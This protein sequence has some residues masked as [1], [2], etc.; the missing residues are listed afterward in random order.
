MKP[1]SNL[2]RLV[3][4]AVL[5]LLIAHPSALRASD[6]GD[7]PTPANNQGV[8]VADVFAFL[9]PND[10]TQTVLI[11]TIHGFIP[12][13]EN[14]DLGIF[15]A[16]TRYHFDIE[17][18]GDTVP[19][20]SIDVTFSLRGGVDGPPGREILQ[21]PVAQTATVRM[22]RFEDLN[23]TRV[24][25]VHEAPTT[26]SSTLIAA[27][28]FVVTS[29]VP[30]AGVQFFAGMTDDPFFFDIPAFQSYIGSVRNGAPNPSVFSR[31]RDSFAGYNVMAIA[32]RIPSQILQ[33]SNT[34]EIGVSFSAQRQRVQ[35]IAK[36]G[37]I[38][39]SGPFV[40]YDRLANPLV[41]LVLVPIDR[42]N[43][44]NRGTPKDDAK[45]KFADDIVATLVALGTNTTNIDALQELIITHGD[46]LRLELDP[47]V[48]AN[49]GT[50]GGNSAG[51][52]FPNGRRLRDDVLDILTNVITN[53]AITTGDN[54]NANDVTLQNS[55]PFL[56]LPQQPRTSG[57]VDDNTRN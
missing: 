11:A 18:T 41:N 10:N 31:A 33:G 3:S 46:Y 34:S 15:D 23:G 4:F 7:S 55:F 9:D 44:Y 56:A 14:V 43:E 29:L 1:R 40:T 16:A 13:G 8:D 57:V 12:S 35:T 27:N 39:G 50:G 22:N 24:T 36:T 47:A 32:L 6:H 49:S 52:G 38:K 51:G 54:V 2:G 17:N 48:I 21:V 37:A 45:G 42:R 19:D 28:P 26:N 30:A 20:K 53:G 5:T 25:G